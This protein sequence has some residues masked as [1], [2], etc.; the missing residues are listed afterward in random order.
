[1]KYPIVFPMAIMRVRHALYTVHWSDHTTTE[2][3]SFTVF[4]SLEQYHIDAKC[5]SDERK[6]KP[7]QSMGLSIISVIEE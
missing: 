6:T 7:A 4:I 3:I 1:V 2:T 5:S